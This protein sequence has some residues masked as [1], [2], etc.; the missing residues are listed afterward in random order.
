MGRLRGL[1]VEEIMAIEANSPSQQRFRIALACVGQGVTDRQ[2]TKILYD[3]GLLTKKEK[4]EYESRV[5]K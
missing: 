2:Y 4:A 5:K 3:K 1:G